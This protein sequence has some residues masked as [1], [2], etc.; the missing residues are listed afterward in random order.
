LHGA[1]LNTRKK[2]QKVTELFMSFSKNLTY[3]RFGKSAKFLLDRSGVEEDKKI[4]LFA[5]QQY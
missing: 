2:R 3:P 5:I 4:T 1:E